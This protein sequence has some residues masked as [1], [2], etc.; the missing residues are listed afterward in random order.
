MSDRW[1]PASCSSSTSPSG[2]GAPRSVRPTS[3]SIPRASPRTTRSGGSA[4]SR[5]RPSIP[6]R[7]VVRQARYALD[8]L[9]HP[10][11]DG[12][13]FVLDATAPEVEAQLRRGQARFEAAVATFLG[14]IPPTGPAM[15]AEWE[16]AAARPGRP[17]A[18]P[19]TRPRS[20]TPSSPASR[21]P[22][23]ARPNSAGS[24][25]SCSESPRR[26]SSARAG[27]GSGCA[28]HA[29]D[30]MPSCSPGVPA[31]GSRGAGP[32]RYAGD[33]SSRHPAPGRPSVAPTVIGDHQDAVGHRDHGFLVPALAHDAAVARGQRRPC[34]ASPPGPPRSGPPRS[35]GCP[36]RSARPVLARTL[37]IARAQAR[38][39]GQMP[40]AREARSCPTRSPRASPRAVRAR[41]R[42][43]S[44][45]RS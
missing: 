11:P 34:A 9:S 1:P 18:G 24:S 42:E 5:S 13:R 29:A 12:S 14:P 22:P 8:S 44:S 19:A 35:H 30:S 37:V 25:T 23:R 27:R 7:P 31:L 26:D 36:A 39:T 15:A 32:A 2:P 4:S 6:S 17:R 45:R 40:R 41:P 38:P 33:R 21:R 20:S 16:A 43:S 10:L 3:A 28:S